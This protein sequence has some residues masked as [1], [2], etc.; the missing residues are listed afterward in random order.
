MWTIVITRANDSLIYWRIYVPYGCCKYRKKVNILSKEQLSNC[1]E[2][3]S[4]MHFEIDAI[5][6]IPT[7][8]KI[9]I[10]DTM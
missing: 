1:T 3:T 5:R 8:S 4:T 6:I 10:D 7:V 9:S 2:F